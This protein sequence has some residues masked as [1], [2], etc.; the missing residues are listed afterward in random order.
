[1]GRAFDFTGSYTVFLTGLSALMLLAA[2]L[3]LCL[4]SYS[5]NLAPAVVAAADVEA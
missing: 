2:C 4:P 5:A 3:M 1:M